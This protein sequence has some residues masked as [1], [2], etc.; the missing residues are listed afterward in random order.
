[1][2]LAE[3]I[4]VAGTGIKLPLNLHAIGAVCSNAYYAPKRFAA[5]QLAFSNPRCRVLIFRE[6]VL[7]LE[8]QRA[9]AALTHVV[10]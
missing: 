3:A 10:C 9:V 5:L 1:M 7:K 8:S 2:Q 6:R 4:P